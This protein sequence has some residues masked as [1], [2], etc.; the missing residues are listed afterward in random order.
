MALAGGP[1]LPTSVL[2]AAAT[3]SGKAS[4]GKA[5]RVSAKDNLNAIDGRQERIAK[6][7]KEQIARTNDVLEKVEFD[8]YL[9]ASP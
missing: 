8:E 7:A 3:E 1:P 5:S 6:V 2:A 4:V 9:M